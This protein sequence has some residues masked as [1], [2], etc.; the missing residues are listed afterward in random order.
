MW[1]LFWFVIGPINIVNF[2]KNQSGKVMRTSYDN[3][4]LLKAHRCGI[5][6]LPVNQHNWLS[7]VNGPSTG[8]IVWQQGDYCVKAEVHIRNYGM[9]IGFRCAQNNMPCRG[10]LTEPIVLESPRAGGMH[11][12][13]YSKMR[14][15]EK[16]CIPEDKILYV[17]SN[18][19]GPFYR[20]FGG[21]DIDI[22]EFVDRTVPYNSILHHATLCPAV[23]K[24][25]RSLKKNI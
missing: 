12:N 16:T 1:S 25:K 24:Q 19:G 6:K 10:S 22:F 11:I 13:P 7:S 4:R 21:N 14:I 17:A 2:G 18:A 20:C 3:R 8:F 15:S 9:K 5:R 23:S